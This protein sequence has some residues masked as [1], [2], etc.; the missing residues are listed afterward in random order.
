M[1]RS[2]AAWTKLE[3]SGADIVFRHHWAGLVEIACGESR[4]MLSYCGRER[5]ATLPPESAVALCRS[6]LYA[7]RVE[8]RNK[9]SAELLSAYLERGAQP[10]QSA[11]LDQT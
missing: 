8:R 4:V 9:A 5:L 7:A 11:E 6:L 10:G 3:C 1:A 2:V